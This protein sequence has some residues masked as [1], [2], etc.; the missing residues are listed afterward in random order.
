MIRGTTP[1]L[2]FTLP[3][4]CSTLTKANIAFAQNGHVVLEKDLT[5]CTVDGNT[6]TLTLSENDTLQ[7]NSNHK[8]VEI[9]IRAAVG[10]TRLASNIVQTTVNR[11]LKDGCL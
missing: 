9:Q 4:D 8:V 7:L 5:E 10:E 6:L 2:T 1:T 11:I 3:F